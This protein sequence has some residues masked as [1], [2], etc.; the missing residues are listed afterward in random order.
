MSNIL[1]VFIAKAIINLSM[2]KIKELLY[3]K[4]AEFVSERIAVLEQA[5]V[6]AREAASDDTKS[7]AGDKYETTREM[8]QQE[9]SRNQKQLLEARKLK[10][11]LETIH[12]GSRT[13]KIQNG[14]LTITSNG[15]FYISISA[16]QINLENDTFFAISQVSPMGRVLLGLKKGQKTTFNGKEIEILEV[17]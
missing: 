11:T 14:S 2:L 8:M 3:E 12:P 6:S 5:I 4:C 9:I 16:G 15:K 13:S 10:H 7:S 17:L 1:W